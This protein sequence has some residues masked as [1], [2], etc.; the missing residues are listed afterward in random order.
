MHCRF[1]PSTWN[2]PLGDSADLSKITLNKM[3]GV[4]SCFF[5][6]WIRADTIYKIRTICYHYTTFKFQHQFHD[7]LLGSH[8]ELLGIIH[9]V[10][11]TKRHHQVPTLYSILPDFE[12]VNVRPLGM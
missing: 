12:L 4:L 6:Y 11:T 7:G 10:V 3:L 1:Q 5:I 8:H 2:Y 9:R